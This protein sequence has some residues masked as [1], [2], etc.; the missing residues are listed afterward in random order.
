MAQEVRPIKPGNNWPISHLNGG[1]AG[2]TELLAA[3]GPALSH[4]ITGFILS[5][6]ADGDGFNLIRRSCVQ[7]YGTN[8]VITIPDSAANTRFGTGDFSLSFWF[9]WYSGAV[10]AMSGL[11]SK[12]D[13]SDKY[14]I[15]LTS[16]GTIKATIGDGT[17]TAS[18]TGSR[19][20]VDGNWHFICLTV[21]RDVSTGMKLYIDAIVDS[22]ADPTAVTGNVNGGGTG[23]DLTMTGIAARVQY[24]SVLRV[25]KGTAMSASGVAAYYANGIGS[26]DKDYSAEML[27]QLD[28]GTGSTAYDSGGTL[29]ATL[30]N[31]NWVDDGIPI[32][33]HTLPMIDKISCG[34]LTTSGV[35]DGLGVLFPHAIKMGRN[36]PVNILETDGGFTLILFGFTD[37]A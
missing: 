2:K 11:L 33:P 18:V 16:S 1:S 36:N 30:A 27:W 22:S 34:V 31:I 19:S 13:G 10:A 4:Y 23:S 8:A 28:E 29:D 9:K 12:A 14:V 32:D 24:I 26:K 6:G 37:G 5:G 25:L 17:H 20:V 21:D 15:E 3:P 7:L 35:F